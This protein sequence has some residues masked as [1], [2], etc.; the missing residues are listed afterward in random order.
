[1]MVIVMGCMTVMNHFGDGDQWV[2]L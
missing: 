2:T 1:M